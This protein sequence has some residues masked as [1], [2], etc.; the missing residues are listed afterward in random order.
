[1]AEGVAGVIAIGAESGLPGGL[2]LDPVMAHRSSLVKLELRMETLPHSQP[3][4]LD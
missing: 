1:M 2:G 3:I 4:P